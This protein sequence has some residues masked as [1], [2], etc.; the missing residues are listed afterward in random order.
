[1]AE[2]E[3]GLVRISCCF[4]SLLAPDAAPRSHFSSFRYLVVVAPVPRLQTAGPGSAVRWRAQLGKTHPIEF[5]GDR[6]SPVESVR[7][8][9]LLADRLI[10]TGRPDTREE[11]APCGDARCRWQTTWCRCLLMIKFLQLKPSTV[12]P[13]NGHDVVFMPPR[14]KCKPGL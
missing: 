4:H 12:K 10:R 7:R 6:S 5:F 2:R 8:H 1:M 13:R 9:L 11:H 14:K 3:V